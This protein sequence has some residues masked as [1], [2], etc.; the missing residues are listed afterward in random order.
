MPHQWGTRKQLF[1][2][3]FRESIDSI[4]LLP[5]MLDFVL[6]K[7]YIFCVSSLQ[8]RRRR[9]GIENKN[10]CLPSASSNAWPRRVPADDDGRCCCCWPP[11]SALAS[12]RR[13]AP[14]TAATGCGATTSHSHLSFIRKKNK[15]RDDALSSGSQSQKRRL[16][17]GWWTS[18]AAKN[19]SF[20]RSFV[21]GQK[22]SLSE[23]ERERTPINN[24]S[25]KPS[26]SF[27]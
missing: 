5:P 14:S 18:G 7:L 12:T 23:R 10:K 16:A 17:D 13:H 24:N 8:R 22:L 9:R 25:S 4:S 2:H 11:A 21:G 27:Y 19:G 1:A 20:V 15:L 6:L 26:F 3:F